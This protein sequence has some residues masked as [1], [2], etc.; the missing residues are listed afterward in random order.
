MTFSV[1]DKDDESITHAGSFS[2]GTYYASETVRG[3]D[4]LETLVERLATYS[5]S[6]DAYR[7]SLANS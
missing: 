4:T 1:K 7:A 6:A 2:L 3:N 5:E